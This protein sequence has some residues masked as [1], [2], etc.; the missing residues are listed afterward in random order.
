MVV[1]IRTHD[2]QAGR[3]IEIEN[4]EIRSR[5]GLHAAPTVELIFKTAAVGARLL[6]PPIDQ[7]EQIDALKNFLVR[8]EGPDEDGCGLHRPS[9]RPLRPVGNSGARCPTA[10]GGSAP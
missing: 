8:L 4:G 3:Y 2:G 7:L 10:H 9:W 1:Q 6:M 5:A